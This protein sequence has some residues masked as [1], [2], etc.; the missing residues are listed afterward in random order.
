MEIVKISANLLTLARLAV[1]PAVIWLILSREED[2]GASWYLFALALFVAASDLFDG[3]LARRFNATSR[4]GT[5]FD[6]LADKII[7]LG[8]AYCF[9]LVDRYWILPVALLFAREIPVGI[10]RFRHMALGFSVPASQLAKWKTTLQ[11]LALAAAAF[12]PFKDYSS[13]HTVLIWVAVAITLYTGIQYLT[14]SKTQIEDS[15][16]QP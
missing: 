6:P 13:L 5:F 16:S 3:M 9:V 10:L 8:S 12:L 4:W 14:A 15:R 7:V 1:S 2:K 11:G